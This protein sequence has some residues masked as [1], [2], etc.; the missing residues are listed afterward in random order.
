MEKQDKTYVCVTICLYNYKETLSI[1]KKSITVTYGR[2]G[3]KW[4]GEFFCLPFQNVFNFEEKLNTF[5]VFNSQDM[6]TS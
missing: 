5:S 2:G 3:P 1:H 6:E 4:E